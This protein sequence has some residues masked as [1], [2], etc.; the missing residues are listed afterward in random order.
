ML[1]ELCMSRIPSPLRGLLAA[2]T[3]SLT[4][5]ACVVGPAPEG[6]YGGG[7]VT[8][9]PP[10]AEY[11][12][13]G[14]APSPGWFWVGGYWNWSGNRYNWVRGHWQAPRAGYYWVPH[15]WVRGSRGWRSERGHWSRR[16]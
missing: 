16:R 7:F 10:A 15:R 6:Y 8:A 9:A 1:E 5:T 13:Y 14:V 12:Y 3:L 4:L 11:E 2:L